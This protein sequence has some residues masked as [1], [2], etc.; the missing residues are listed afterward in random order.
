[1]RCQAQHCQQDCTRGRRATLLRR[2]RQRQTTLRSRECQ[3]NLLYPAP[4]YSQPS[5]L[6]T[7]CSS[8]SPT[9]N[10]HPLSLDYFP[11]ILST[12]NSNCLEATPR[13]LPVNLVAVDR[14]TPVYGRPSSIELGA[15][16]SR[17]TKDFLSQ[18]EVNPETKDFL[19]QL[20]QSGP[21]VPETRP[22]HATEPETIDF[23]S[24]FFKGKI[25]RRIPGSGA[26]NSA[27]ESQATTD[28]SYVFA[29][30]PSPAN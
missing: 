22:S 11:S 15:V 20:D 1:M 7:D 24:H 2:V 9:D 4:D 21:A 17:E 18:L 5:W 10:T 8:P 6:S 29:S 16:K 26:V 27:Q 3:S 25:K 28:R 12:D 14:A 23:L 19:S 13:Q 30:P